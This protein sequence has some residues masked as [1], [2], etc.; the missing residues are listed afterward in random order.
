MAVVFIRRFIAPSCYER[1]SMESIAWEERE[2]MFPQYTEFSFF[3]AMDM[4]PVGFVLIPSKDIYRRECHAS[5]NR[6]HSRL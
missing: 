1:N 5:T 4:V 2:I 6:T 3:P